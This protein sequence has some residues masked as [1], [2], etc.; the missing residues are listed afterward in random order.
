MF[1]FIFS[2]LIE[3]IIV[4]AIGLLFI[5]IVINQYRTKKLG[6]DHSS[7]FKINPDITD[8]NGEAIEENILFFIEPPKELGKILTANSTL[9]KNHSTIEPYIISLCYIGL[10]FITVGA[11]LIAAQLT[12]SLNTF[13][14][15]FFFFL[16]TVLTFLAFVTITNPIINAANLASSYV[17]EKGFVEY[18]GRFENKNIVSA[19]KLHCLFDDFDYLHVKNTHKYNQGHYSGLDYKYIWSGKKEKATIISGEHVKK[20]E[21]DIQLVE[22]TASRFYF[23]QSCKN[24]WDTHILKSAEEKYNRDKVLKFESYQP[25]KSSKE[26]NLD[27]D[28][29]ISERKMDIVFRWPVAGFGRYQAKEERITLDA[30]DIIK[31]GT[32]VDEVSYTDG[33][34]RYHD[35]KQMLYIYSKTPID[36]NDLNV[37][38]ETERHGIKVDSIPNTQLFFWA[39]ERLLHLKIQDPIEEEEKK[40]EKE[41]IQLAGNDFAIRFA[42]EERFKK[43]FKTYP[44]E[45]TGTLSIQKD[46]V[47]YHSDKDGVP[48]LILKTENIKSE[49]IGS[50]WPN[51][52]THWFVINDTK[53]NYYFSANIPLDQN[54][55]VTKTI[56]QR[57]L[58]TIESQ[59][60]NRPLH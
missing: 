50:G 54:A 7:F 57:I 30:A 6:S 53:D 4:L 56:H 51:G 8:H 10:L 16:P 15:I 2:M 25:G 58:D 11:F 43:V 29:F 49:W 14:R 45:S 9:T 32:K 28:I 55:H 36:K 27:P 33:I 48:P 5:G 26:L 31:I 17:G 13:W 42:S 60:T 47:Q 41:E 23:V 44:W 20:K 46:S 38:Y 35:V 39:I 3:G 21:L 19:I 59:N 34:K 12:T 18:Q 37:S 52:S 22:K 1:S 40:E 24:A